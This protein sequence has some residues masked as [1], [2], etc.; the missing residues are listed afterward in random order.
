LHW[1]QINIFQIF[2]KL[3]HPFKM[4]RL[5]KLFADCIDLVLVL[6]AVFYA[7]EIE[8]TFC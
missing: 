2:D 6:S 5:K 3:F 4:P 1:Q 8:K 7:K